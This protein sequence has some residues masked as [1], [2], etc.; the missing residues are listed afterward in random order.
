MAHADHSKVGFRFAR[1]VCSPDQYHVSLFCVGKVEMCAL[2]KGDTKMKRMVT[3]LAVAIAFTVLAASARAQDEG[4]SGKVK[5]VDAGRNEMILKGITSDTT[6]EVAK[7]ATIWLD[8]KHC[9]LADFKADDRVAV[10]YKKDG[11]RMIAS[12]IR[13]LRNKDEVTG[14]IRELS[15]QKK[16]LIIK[17]L[18]KDTTYELTNDATIWVNGKK[19]TL[20]DLKAGDEARITYARQGDQGLIANDVVVFRK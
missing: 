4:T 7:D 17:G 8:G 11:N 18:V 6:L 5:S 14:S 19:S 9:K 20:A 3:M 2:P 10:R 15:E 1:S 12:Y 13:G 16:Q